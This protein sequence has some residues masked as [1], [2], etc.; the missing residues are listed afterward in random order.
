MHNAGFVH[1]VK[2]DLAVGSDGQN[3]GG[4][5][6]GGGGAGEQEASKLAVDCNLRAKHAAARARTLGAVRPHG[7]GGCAAVGVL[8]GAAVRMDE[9]DACVRAEGTCQL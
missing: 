6:Q 1:E 2:R 4:A 8:V 3:V 5:C 7:H 9:G